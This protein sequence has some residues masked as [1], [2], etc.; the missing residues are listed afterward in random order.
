[1]E[2]EYTI[3]DLWLLLKKYF[4]S[5]I[6]MTILGATIAAIFVMFF[7]EPKYISQAQLIV[8]QQNSQDSAIQY[9]EVQTNVT[10][11]STYRDIILGDGVLTRVS[12]QLDN[13]FSITELRD[14][15]SIVQS[16]ESQAFNISATMLSPKDA[17]TVVNTV[18]DVFGSSLKEI[19]GDNVSNVYVASAASY[20]ENQVSPN[21][22]LFTIVGGV[23]G[24]MIMIIVGVIK[25]LTD[26][27]V[28]KS[29]DIMDLGLV[30]LG[31]IYNLSDEQI[32]KNRYKNNEITYNH[33]K[34]V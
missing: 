1:M 25:D 19:Y 17:Q 33:R 2:K 24:A 15:L 30:R 22:L 12:D 23:T 9:T 27:R 28:K 5:I 7:A 16:T 6:N 14:S 32:E 8:N 26:N 21:I 3:Y 11:I 29:E 10:L 4:V 18:I 34:R 31:E 20:N 13:Q